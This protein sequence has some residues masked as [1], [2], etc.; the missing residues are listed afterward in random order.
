MGRRVGHSMAQH[1]V[2]H[3]GAP[4]AAGTGVLRLLAAARTGEPARGPRAVEAGSAAM[5]E[6]RDK[7]QL[8][9]KNTLQHAFHLDEHMK[10]CGV[11]SSLEL[12]QRTGEIP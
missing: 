10:G 7:S 5:P 9:L 12:S 3:W 2:I 11:C 4:A 8:A 1:G 6:Q